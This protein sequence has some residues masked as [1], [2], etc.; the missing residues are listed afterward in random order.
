MSPEYT[1]KQNRRRQVIEHALSVIE[2]LASSEASEAAE[3]SRSK[4]NLDGPMQ[5]K[6]PD[7]MIRLEYRVSLHEHQHKVYKEK[8]LELHD[9]LD[10]SGSQSGRIESGSVLVWDYKDPETSGAKNETVI[11]IPSGGGE[12]GDFRLLSTSA[13]LTKAIV[14]KKAG[15]KVSFGEITVLI[16]EVL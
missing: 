9:L 16:K 5:S 2:N 10:S 7:E 3:L 13:P 15:D 12:L 8:A 4:S 11:V 1:Q 14:G 6:Q